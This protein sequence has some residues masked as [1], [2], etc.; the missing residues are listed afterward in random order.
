MGRPRKLTP[1]HESLIRR[2]VRLRRRLTNKALAARFGVSDKTI[3]MVA[4]NS[5]ARLRKKLSAAGCLAV[6][7]EGA[8]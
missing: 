7:H 3:I 1:D 6:K 8:S 2:M 4:S 5:G